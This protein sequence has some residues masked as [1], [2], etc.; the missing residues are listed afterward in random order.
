MGLPI[1]PAGCGRSLPCCHPGTLPGRQHEP[2]VRCGG[3]GQG[4]AQ[5]TEGG[6]PFG[7]CRKDVQLVVRRAC[8]PIKTGD[9]E[10]VAVYERRNRALELRP[11]RTR[12]RGGFAEHLT[13]RPRSA[14]SPAPRRSGRRLTPSRNRRSSSHCET[15]S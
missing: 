15:T 10:H 7:D 5:R 2:A 14:R 8:Q 3:V 9:E 1:L 13:G 6:T 4:V 11:V 12:P